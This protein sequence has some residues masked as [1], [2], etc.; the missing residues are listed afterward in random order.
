MEILKE[1]DDALMDVRTERQRQLD[2]WKM[3]DHPLPIWVVINMEEMGEWAHEAL[4][5]NLPDFRKEG[6]EVAA[7]A[8]AAMESTKRQ[9][10]GQEPCTA[11][12]SVTPEDAVWL[13]RIQF[14]SGELAK[15]IL[16]G[17]EEA[18]GKALTALTLTIL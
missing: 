15:A 8:V 16:D 11:Y 10:A 4:A 12:T 9:L 7:V 13:C 6:K 17:N 5:G 18:R 14:W 3:Q 1:T 2:K